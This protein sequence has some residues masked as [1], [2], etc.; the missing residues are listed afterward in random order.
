MCARSDEGLLGAAFVLPGRLGMAAL[1]ALPGVTLSG[2]A[3]P[4]SVRKVFWSGSKKENANSGS[5]LIPA[6]SGTTACSKIFVPAMLLGSAPS[7]LLVA[8]Y[9]LKSF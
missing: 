4:L 2:N 5:V 8:G 6:R 3:G 9:V 1:L 7:I